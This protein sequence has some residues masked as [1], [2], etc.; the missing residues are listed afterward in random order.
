MGL[1]MKEKLAGVISGIKTEAD[2]LA[3]ESRSVE[4]RWEGDHPKSVEKEE[5]FG[6]GLRVFREGEV[7]LA[8][9]KDRTEL[10]DL[11]RRA[12]ESFFSN[13]GWSIAK[14]EGIYPD[15]RT[16]EEYRE[17]EAENVWKEFRGLYKEAMENDG[18]TDVL[19]MDYSISDTNV[20]LLTTSGID[21][22]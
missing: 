10:G 3:V 17:E 22:F 5:S 8:W 19:D 13:P 9:T 6:A 7:S 4:Y 11:P 15:I 14:R 21:L 2:I 12:E 1:E 18:I 20:Y 16:G